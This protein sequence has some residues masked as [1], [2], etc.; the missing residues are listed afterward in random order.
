MALRDITYS[1]YTYSIS[2]EIINPTCKKDIVILH[3][4]GSNKEIMKNSFERFLENFRQIYLDLPGFGN[5]NIFIPLKSEDYKNI[6]E[7]FLQSLHVEKN[8]IIGHSFGGKIATLLNPKV[9]VLLS[10]A[11]ILVEKSFKVKTKIKLFKTLK[12]F[13]PQKTYTLFATKDVSGMSQVMYETLKNVVDEDFSFIF[14]KRQETT[15]LFWGEKDTSTPLTSGEK[16]HA[17]I[18][19]S[20]FYSYDGD[21]FFFSKYA[22]DIAQKINSKVF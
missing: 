17:L 18:E 1:G 4:W 11:G 8:I 3:G 20:E 12:Y 2:Y 5:S 19:N 22:K 21:H 7:L 15:L 13:L 14:A 9:L 10:S 6:V 16:I